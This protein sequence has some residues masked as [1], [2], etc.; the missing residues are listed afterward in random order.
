MSG[1]SAFYALFCTAQ[2]PAS[3]VNE[4]LKM[5]EEDA[6]SDNIWT[7]IRN[8]SQKRAD[9]PSEA[10]IEDFETSFTDAS[11]EDLGAFCREKFKPQKTPQ[12]QVPIS[13]EEFAIMDK[14][15][16]KDDTVLLVKYDVWTE[17]KDENDP[18]DEDDAFMKFR[19]WREMRVP[20]KEATSTMEALKELNIGQATPNKDGVYFASH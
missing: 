10:P 6:K 17:R 9:K 2:I 1:P 3:K 7:L 11:L 15:T 19:G 4:L 13:S 5:A 12:G 18:S 14:R 20:I 8:H 16:L